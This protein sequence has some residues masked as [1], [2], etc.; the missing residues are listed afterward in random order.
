MRIIAYQLMDHPVTIRPAPL[1]RDWMSAT[2]SKFAY[3]C[4]PLNIANMHGWEVLSPVTFWAEWD[5][6]DALE[7]VRIESDGPEELHPL[8]HF[9]CGVL[10]FNVP[11]LFRTPPGVNML[12]TGPFNR[13]RHGIQALTGIVETDWAPYSF[14]MNWRFTA[15]GTRIW[16]EKDEPYAMLCPV[17]RGYVETAEPELQRIEGAPEEQAAYKAWSSSRNQF[18][19]DLN[20]PDS[21][22]RRRGWQKNYFQGRKLDGSPGNAEHQTKL[23]VKPWRPAKG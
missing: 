15:P 9:G 23:E 10:T 5:G 19:Q 3:R 13:V 7:S 22:A 4:L 14:T 21:E 1:E 8:S 6:G 20:E 17:P 12:V 11:W 18:N 2:P 16:W